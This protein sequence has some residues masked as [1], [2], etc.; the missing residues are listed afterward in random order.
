MSR[1]DLFSKDNGAKYILAVDMHKMW[2]V[3]RDLQYISIW[4]YINTLI[5]YRIVHIEISKCL[6][7]LS[8]VFKVGGK[9]SVLVRKVTDYL[10]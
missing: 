9:H 2:I 8:G 4:Q 1:T 10:Y 7:V 6:I 3:T 5:K